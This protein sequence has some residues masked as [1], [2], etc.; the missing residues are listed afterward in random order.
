M[1]QL[2][3]KPGPLTASPPR[4]LIVEDER[5]VAADLQRVLTELGYDAADCAASGAD[6]M[7]RAEQRP[8]DVVLMD[9]RLQG[10]LDGIETGARLRAQFGASII[11][12]TAHSDDATIE[13]AKRS[14]PA[15]YLLKPATAAALKAAIEL[16]LDRRGRDAHA[17]LRELALARQHERLSVALDSLQ[18]ALQV[19]DHRRAV[20]YVNRTF[21][22]MFGLRESP[23]EL[24]GSDGA[25]LCD[26]IGSLTVAPQQFALRLERLIL[27]R[28]RAAGDRLELLDE[29]TIE[30]EYLPTAGDVGRGHLWAYRDVTR[31]ERS[32]EPEPGPDDR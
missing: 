19:E 8:P 14:E 13:R 4:V 1:M 11:Y 5:I 10:P 29:R 16:A 27:A 15:G 21:C 32:T 12:L 17:L 20:L 7:R 24:V 2:A 18:L 3:F 22:T 23:A 6:A 26:H 28:Q 25:A 9:I 31:R 30:R